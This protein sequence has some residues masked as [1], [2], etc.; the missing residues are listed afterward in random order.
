MK[1]VVTWLKVA[2]SKEA[3]LWELKLEKGSQ[4]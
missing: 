3:S 1:A 2:K 4:L